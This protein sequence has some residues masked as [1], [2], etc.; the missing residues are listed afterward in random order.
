[1]ALERW[2]GLAALALRAFAAVDVIA[3]GAVVMAALAALQFVNP[4]STATS[5][6]ACV[7]DDFLVTRIDVTGL[8][9]PLVRK[10]AVLLFFGA[11][12]LGNS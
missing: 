10:H 11:L 1:M 9:R 3:V 2:A 6:F 5:G 12:A 4:M 8:G 7:A